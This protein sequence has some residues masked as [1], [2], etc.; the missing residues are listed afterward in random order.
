MYVCIYIYNYIIINNNKKNNSNNSNNNN[1]IYMVTSVVG[2]AG[3]QRQ[4]PN[5]RRAN[6]FVDFP[7][8]FLEPQLICF[9]RSLL[10][11]AQNPNLML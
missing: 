9:S 10:V 6:G 3:S 5:K 2:S 8:V 4:T 7:D 11:T 1:N